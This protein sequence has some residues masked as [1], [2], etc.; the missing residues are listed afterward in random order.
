MSRL[1][2]MISEDCNFSCSY[3]YH[4]REKKE[5][6]RGT[7]EKAF[8]FFLPRMGE[9]PEIYFLGGEPLLNVDL[10]RYA[11]EYIEKKSAQ[12][13]KKGYN[14]S[15]NGSLITPEILK[16]FNQ[17]RFTVELSF[18]GLAQ[19]R[20]R[21]K[22]SF[23]RLVDVIQQGLKFPNIQ[24]VVNSVFSPPTVNFLSESIRFML[25]L[26]VPHLSLGLALD[27]RWN[28][29]SVDKFETE[30]K[31]LMNT[32]LDHYQ[33]AGKQP[34]H[35]FPNLDSKGIWCCSAGQSQLTVSA[36]GEVWGCALFYE[37]F[38][39]RRTPEIHRNYCFG[40]I[41]KMSS[42]NQE[43]SANIVEHYSQLC[44]D[45][46][47]TDESRCFLCPHIEFCGVCPISSA[48]YWN[49]P[50]RV[51]DYICRINRI[52]IHEKLKFQRRLD[53]IDGRN[54]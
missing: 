34:L 51:P 14:I 36:E 52:A 38:R 46:F 10:I 6:S 44:Q 54:N 9:N 30:Y 28:R 11:V 20:A 45:N 48:L 31:K 27:R 23:H 50:D 33:K 24:L 49:R 17:H 4:K 42:E 37:Y 21:Q 16:F 8:D 40:T 3:C 39:H 18:D 12:L 1:V 35:F 19:E 5:M 29:P 41:E 47:F 22:G 2:L 15:T 32:L 53:K 26:G 25:D 43:I 7:A 13:K